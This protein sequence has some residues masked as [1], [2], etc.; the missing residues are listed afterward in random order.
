MLQ[1]SGFVGHGFM[2]APPS[3]SGWPAWMVNDTPDELFTRFDWTGFRTGKLERETMISSAEAWS[4]A[5]D[6]RRFHRAVP[7]V[8]GG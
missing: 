1:M 2:M 5:R 7:L 3:R 8:C 6:W 4:V